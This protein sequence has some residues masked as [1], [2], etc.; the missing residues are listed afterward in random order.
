MKS[1]TLTLEEFVSL[2]VVGNGCAITDLPSII[3]AEH[4]ARLVAL[5]FIADLFGSL[6][7]TASGR[8]R[9]AAGFENKPQL[10]LSQERRAAVTRSRPLSTSGAR[11]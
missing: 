4:S 5:G 3:P 9:I 2:L 8:L 10:A 1:K 7:M 11:D 6:R